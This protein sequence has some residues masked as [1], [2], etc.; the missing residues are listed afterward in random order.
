M[1]FYDSTIAADE[2]KYEVNSV[3]NNLYQIQHTVAYGKSNPDVFSQVSMIRPKVK[4]RVEFK[5]NDNWKIA[6]LCKQPKQTDH[7]TT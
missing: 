4:S 6:V 3:V 5:E 7:M 2:I 1:Y